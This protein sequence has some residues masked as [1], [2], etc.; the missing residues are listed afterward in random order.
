MPVRKLN[1]HDITPFDYSFGGAI[2]G[3][4]TDIGRNLGSSAIGLN[5]QTVPPGRSRQ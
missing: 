5:I 1:I 2:G 3:Q 4:M